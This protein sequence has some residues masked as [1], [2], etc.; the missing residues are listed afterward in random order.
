MATLRNRS[1]RLLSGLTWSNGS[2]PGSFEIG[3]TKP[4]GVITEENLQVD[5]SSVKFN[6]A[7]SVEGKAYGLPG[8]SGL[9]EDRMNSDLSLGLKA[10]SGEYRLSLDLADVGRPAI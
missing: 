7:F 4:V 5:L 2:L 3:A 9:I 10:P 8:T 6:G 1:T